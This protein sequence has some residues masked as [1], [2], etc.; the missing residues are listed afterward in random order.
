[1]WLFPGTAILFLRTRTWASETALINSVHNY[2]KTNQEWWIKSTEIG[3]SHTWHMIPDKGGWIIE[4]V[5]LKSP[6][7]IK[8]VEPPF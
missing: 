4:G 2:G 3:T 7:T 8:N 6:R 5:Y 1:M